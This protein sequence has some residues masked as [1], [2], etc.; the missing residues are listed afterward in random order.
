V[1]TPDTVA[2]VAAAKDLLDSGKKEAAIDL[3]REAID[4]FPQQDAD[5]FA[6]L[7][8]LYNDEEGGFWKHR[9]EIDRLLAQ[10]FLCDNCRPDLMLWR[11]AITYEP[12]VK[13]AILEQSLQRWPSDLTVRAEYAWAI[14]KDDRQKS[15]QIVQEL[16]ALPP[17][18]ALWRYL[19]LVT[20]FYLSLNQTPTDTWLHYDRLAEEFPDAHFTAPI[21]NI[22]TLLSGNVNALERKQTAS[23][24]TLEDKLLLAVGDA[25]HGD[26]KTAAERLQTLASEFDRGKFVESDSPVYVEWEDRVCSID[27]WDHFERLLLSLHEQLRTAP[28]AA[29]YLAAL[30]CLEVQLGVLR[31]SEGWPAAS[32]AAA[33]TNFLIEADGKVSN[34]RVK[35]LLHRHYLRKGSRRK[36]ITYALSAYRLA[37]D[38]SAL[39]E[40]SPLLDP[41]VG[42]EERDLRDTYT[43]RD[44]SALVKGLVELA[45]SNREAALAFYWDYAR[46]C[47]LRQGIPPG[48][49]LRAA[50]ALQEGHPLD[51]NLQFDIALAYH[52][53]GEL[54]KAK[55]AYAVTITLNPQAASAYYNLSLISEREEDLEA[56]AKQ[57]ANALQH[58]QDEKWQQR[59][60]GLRHK[61]NAAVEIFRFGIVYNPNDPPVPVSVEELTLT[62]AIYTTAVLYALQNSRTGGLHPALQV[63]SPVSPAPELDIKIFE[64]L[65]ERGI[66]KLDP[67]SPKVALAADGRI[68]YYP[69]EA[70]WIPN[71]GSHQWPIQQLIALLEKHIVQIAGQQDTTE[72]CT[73]WREAALWETIAYF[74]SRMEAYRLSVSDTEGIRETFRQIVEKYSIGNAWY[75]VYHSAKT[76]VA[77][78]EERGLTKPHAVNLALS[79]CRSRADKTRIENWHIKP[80]GRVTQLP[81]SSLA[82]LLSKLIGGT[83][84][85][86]EDVPYAVENKLEV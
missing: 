5:L 37:A 63:A 19:A 46:Y 25:K 14:S 81:E 22:V 77:Q 26:L 34:V 9:D 79:Y 47:L 13:R 70:I 66:L 27:I 84:R 78:R 75:I 62:E 44:A 54:A 29:T 64:T 12:K 55:E 76:A 49:L 1:T 16:L 50:T 33:A 21:A 15:V 10:A 43:Y 30:G 57:C 42:P 7:A 72:L 52:H 18:R 17:E 38:Q 83:V 36:A 28:E 58:R 59:L 61:A 67:S 60:E 53:K 73:L 31:Q 2:A 39:E 56:A 80:Y 23:A 69:R 24:E 48:E 82:F 74:K 51:S 20:Q 65:G 45:T 86:W 35:A 68:K 85:Y 41:Y 71:I 8:S 11:A 6:M 40:M 32:A 3:L 4:R